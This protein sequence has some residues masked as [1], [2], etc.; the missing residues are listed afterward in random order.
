MATVTFNVGG[1][2]FT[3]STTCVYKSDKL[4][5]LARDDS[6]VIVLDY[7]YEAF[8]IVLD[9]LRHDEVL[10]PPSVCARTV[11]LIL[12]EL[13][14]Y[15]PEGHRQKLREIQSSQRTEM[16]PETDLAPPQ[17]FPASDPKH[18]SE[19]KKKVSSYNG[20]IVEQLESTVHQKIA[21]LVL[22]TIRPRLTSQALQGSYNTTYVLLPAHAK[23]SVLLSEFPGT[24]FT[25]I[26]YLDDDMQRFLGQAEVNR[27]LEAAL[28]DCVGV[29]FK[30]RS[31]DVFLRSENEFGIFSTKTVEAMSI[32]FE[33]R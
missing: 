14:V 2:V 25:E 11:E 22:S 17:Y 18:F 31:Q 27:R 24:Q 12:D 9:Y 10:I 23:M 3:I 19:D 32:D 28:V 13:Q 16:H 4:T 26:I 20:D 15:L 33:L 8:A 21:D 30:M 6:R 29:P 5:E 1:K 7:N